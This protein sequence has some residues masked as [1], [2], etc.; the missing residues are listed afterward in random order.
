MN[1]RAV[2]VISR[3]WN[4]ENNLSYIYDPTVANLDISIRGIEDT[5]KK[6]L[7]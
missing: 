7:E 2:L 5:D 4:D 1:L 6:L 3:E